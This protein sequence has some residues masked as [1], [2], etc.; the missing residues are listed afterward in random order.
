MRATSDNTR[1]MVGLLCPR[2]MELWQGLTLRTLGGSLKHMWVALQVERWL[3]PVLPDR[4]PSGELQLRLT[5]VA[6]AWR[7]GD[8]RLRG[9]LALGLV[10]LI[11]HAMDAA[12]LAAALQLLPSILVMLENTPDAWLWLKVVELLREPVW[13]IRFEKLQLCLTI[14]LR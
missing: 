10:P 2:L 6:H 3:A 1:F 11:A 4:V 5:T 13:D 9:E 14:G 8:A 7:E 12:V